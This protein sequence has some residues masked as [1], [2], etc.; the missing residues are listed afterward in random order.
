MEAKGIKEIVKFLQ[1][2]YRAELNSRQ[3]EQ[4][5]LLFQ[6]RTYSPRALRTLFTISISLDVYPVCEYCQCPIN[7]PNQLSIDH[8]QPTSKG[9]GNNVEN[10]QPMH[11]VCNSR[12]GNQIEE[13]VVSG[14]TPPNKRRSKRRFHRTERVSGHDVEELLHKCEE[15]DAACHHKCDPSNHGRHR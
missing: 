11:C 7:D 6:R 5:R 1:K 9:G 14:P 15:V 8:I 3:Y 10:L 13:L 12:K 2:N 4:L